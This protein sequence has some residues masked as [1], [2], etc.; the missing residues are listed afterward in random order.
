[1]NGLMVALA[2]MLFSCVLA[3]VDRAT[4]QGVVQDALGLKSYGRA[5]DGPPGVSAGP[6]GGYRSARRD[7][8]LN[9]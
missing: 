3:E 7:A 1:M 2:N 5:Y 6:L 8:I 4:P 9:A